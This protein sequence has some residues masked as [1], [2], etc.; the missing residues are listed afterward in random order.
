MSHVTSTPT[1]APPLKAAIIP[2]TPLQQNCTLFWCTETNKGALVDPGGDLDRLAQSSERGI[3]A[4][5]E[6]R[7]ALLERTGSRWQVEQVAE[8][9]EPTLVE[10]EQSA[11]AEADARQAE[12]IATAQTVLGRRV[13][14]LY[15]GSVN[16]GNCQELISCPHVDGLFIGRS[17]QSDLERSD[18]QARASITLGSMMPRGLDA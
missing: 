14:C 7:Q 1:Q 12:I 6:L 8:G 2:V 16:P 9:G 18:R 3:L 15:G 17:R 13:P 5:R 4:D 11:K 10:R